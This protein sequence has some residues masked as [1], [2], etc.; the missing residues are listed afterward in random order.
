MCDDENECF[1]GRIGFDSDCNFDF[2]TGDDVSGLD[3]D[4]R[5]V[6]SKSWFDVGVESLRMMSKN[7]NRSWTP[8]K[9]MNGDSNE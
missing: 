4:E 6:D 1:D 5:I 7:M 2:D 8:S 3:F 9:S